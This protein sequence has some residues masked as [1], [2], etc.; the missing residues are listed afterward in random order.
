MANRLQRLSDAT[1]TEWT[2]QRRNQTI[3]CGVVARSCVQSAPIESFLEDLGQSR[4]R[5]VAVALIDLDESP[6]L[7]KR[8]HV[9]AAPALLVMRDG[10]VTAQLINKCT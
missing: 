2:E 7:A 6:A 8:F 5:R 9:D 3:L 4:Q 10:H 1:F